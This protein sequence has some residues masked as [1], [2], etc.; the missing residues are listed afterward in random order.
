SNPQPSVL[1]TDALPIELCPCG[2]K[3]ISLL[4]DGGDDARADGTTAFT[5]GDGP[6]LLHGDRRDQLHGDADV[7]AGH[8]HFL[9]LRQ[10]HGTGHVRRAE[11]ELGTVVVE[12]RG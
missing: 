10:L 1:E 9:V 7:V 11:V 3:T 5:D 4:E 12:E 8:D 2:R 6:A